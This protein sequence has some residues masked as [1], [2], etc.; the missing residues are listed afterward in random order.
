VEPVTYSPWFLD[1]VDS[2]E[3]EALSIQG[4]EVRGVL[5]A[6]QA[7]QGAGARELRRFLTYFPSEQSIEPVVRRLRESSPVAQP[8]RIETAPPQEG[9][10]LRM[11]L[12][13]QA[14]ALLAITF[15]LLR[16]RV[17]PS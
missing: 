13:I 3:I 12:L 8:V 1:R 5:R 6:G 9:G 11:V 4:L 15:V 7:A 2:G 14:V 10:L 16:P 17:G